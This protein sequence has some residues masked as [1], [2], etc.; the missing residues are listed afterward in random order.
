VDSAGAAYVAGN[1]S[2]ENFPSVNAL[3]PF[4]PGD[5]FLARFNPYSGTGDVTLGYSTS[6]GPGSAAAVAVDSTGAVYVAG[7]AGAAFPTIN[8]YQGAHPANGGAFVTKV[9]PFTGGPVTV[10][11][12]T[13]LGGSGSNFINAIAVDSAGAAYI[14]GYT[15]ST[16]FPVVNA[17]QSRNAAAGNGYTDSSANGN[18]FVVR[19]NPFS[20][21]GNVTLGFSTYLGGAA[22][23]LA[24][25]IAVDAAG[26]VYV[27]GLTTSANFP[28]LDPSPPSFSEML[29]DAFV[30]KF[31]PSKKGPLTLAYSTFIGGNEAN[32]NIATYPTAGTGIAIDPSGA[33]QLAGYTYSLNFPLL[34]A[35]Q[36]TYIDVETDAMTDSDGFAVKIPQPGAVVKTPVDVTVTSPTIAS[37]APGQAP[38]RGQ[39]LTLTA[40]FTGASSPPVTGRVWFVG[41]TNGAVLC[42]APVSN[43]GASCTTPAYTPPY[44][45]FDGGGNTITAGY[46][47]DSVYTLG[48]VTPL[49]FLNGPAATTTNL[50]ISP[51]PP[52]VGPVTLTATVTITQPGGAFQNND[53]VKF[54]QNG[55]TVCLLSPPPEAIQVTQ[56]TVS[57]PLTLGS[58]AV[59]LSALY[60]GNTE[61]ASSSAGFGYLVP[62]SSPVPSFDIHVSAAATIYG[63][64]VTI[65]ATS[66]PVP[67]SALPTGSV[68]FYDATGSVI[69]QLASVPLTAGAAS[70]TVPANGISALRAGTHSITVNGTGPAYGGAT[71]VVAKADTMT[72]LA[73]QGST[74][75]AAVSAV[76]PGA[77]V[78]SGG[79]QFFNGSA[80]VAAGNLV[81]SGTQSVVVLP[82]TAIGGN[83]T[84]IYSGD[85]NFN[86]STS[87][88]LSLPKSQPPV[89]VTLTLA[90]SPNPAPVGL[91]VTLTVSVKGNAPAPAAG[92]VQVFD[93]A[94]LLGAA[95]VSGGQATLAATFQSTGTHRLA[96]QYSGDSVYP[97][98][99]LAAGLYV[100]GNSI[101]IAIASSSANTIAGQPV[102]FTA[103][104][105]GAVGLAPPS[106]TVQFLDGAT[107]IATGLV[108]NG[109]ASVTVSSLAPG[110]HRISAFYGGDAVWASA[111]S[112]ALIQSVGGGTFTFQQPSVRG[113]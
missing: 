55:F 105:D 99:S 2:S 45:V 56:F 64:P 113:R 19:M 49:T 111:V 81:T 10:A 46:P 76:S 98:E 106:G 53:T 21:T 97:P 78:P 104:L 57:C 39:P 8:A 5:V 37:L 24:N 3:L 17:W 47:G 68:T 92:M 9:N 69:G 13:L 26:A 95:G 93:S 32:P 22:L 50:S 6:L 48:T 80:E 60:S 63:Q 61:T 29:G 72:T 96:A 85:S 62:F 110:T 88:V 83:I 108:A 67:G 28:V 33:I 65:S 18:A 31:I 87:A 41:G 101:S 4:Q 12:S 89:F 34:N 84:A 94:T 82:A 20:G 27:T 36:N 58:A 11:Y 71:I 102:T 15:T 77:G 54:T 25:G 7:G 1:V 90:S 112:A 30:T 51:N 43:G 38:A 59:T 103:Q 42:S 91:P 79:V 109:A 75:T 100:V 35:Y 44:I 40:T 14:A 66:V 23:D 16:D 52:V 70:I 86:G 73:A 74:V 107:V